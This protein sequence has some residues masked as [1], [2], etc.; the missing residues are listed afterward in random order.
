MQNL[1]QDE[2]YPL[3]SRG[4]VKLEGE[5]ALEALQSLCSNSLANVNSKAVLSYILDE[6]NYLLADVFVVSHDGGLLVECEKTFIA[7]LLE[8]LSL[9]CDGADLS[10]IDCSDQWRVLAEGP[11]QSTFKEGG[12][13]IKY[14][15][16]RWHMGA[17]LL[18]PASDA[19]SYHWGSELKWQGHA[20]KLGVLPGAHAVS[21]WGITPREANLHSQ[22]LLDAACVDTRLAKQLAEPTSD[23]ARRVLPLR[24]E[25]DAFSFPDMTGRAVTAGDSTL[26]TVIEHHGLYGLVLVELTPWRKALQAAIALECAGQQVLITWPSWLAR[27]SQGRAGPVAVAGTSGG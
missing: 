13:Y 12:A 5:D 27:E 20:H 11:D 25:P 6:E 7:P 10:A 1:L 23:I 26:G 3:Q 22:Q 14:V 21:H 15:D 17:R 24:I 18:R 4:V 2:A 19:P 8:L 16:P 9:Y